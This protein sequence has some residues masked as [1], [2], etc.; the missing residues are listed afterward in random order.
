[1]KLKILISSDGP[2]AMYFIRLGIARAMTACGHEVVMWDTSRIPTND[3]FDDFEPHIFIGQ[4]YNVDRVLYNAIQERPHLKVVM[5]GSD[6]GEMMEQIPLKEFPVL[7]V[8][9]DEKEIILK[10]KEELNKPNY[11]EIHYHEDYIQKTHGYWI[12]N[13]VPVVSQL[14][15]ADLFEFHNGKYDKRFASDLTFIGGYWGYKAKVLDKYLL[16][17]CRQNKYNIRIFGNSRWPT[18]AYCGLIEEK[19]TKDV[20][21]SA[22]ICPNL[23]EPHSQVYGYDIIE[24]PFKLL[25]NRCFVISDYVEGLVKLLPNAMVY[26]KTP[27]E[28]FEKVEYYLS[29]M[30]EAIPYIENGYEEVMSKHTYFHRVKD[31]FDRLGLEQEADNCMK[32][33]EEIF[34]WKTRG[35]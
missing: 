11:L 24:R 32:K 9:E 30:S 8:R 13:G 35:F 10:M 26:V 6:W 18:P 28:F 20:L 21:A 33:Y 22:K 15:G 17:L 3:I 29:N 25:S 23:H 2:H 16:E 27:E 14:S 31:I 1:M 7:T 34:K 5:K 4:T 19:Y 12:K